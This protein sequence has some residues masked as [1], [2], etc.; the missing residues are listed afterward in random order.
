MA[1]TNTLTGRENLLNIAQMTHN[2]EIID[3][4]EVLNETNDMIADAHVERAND[5]TSHVVSRRTLMPVPTWTKVGEGWVPTAGLVNQV[6]EGIATMRSR[7]QAPQQ[8][9]DL[10]PNPAKARQQQERAHIEAMGHEFS[11]TVIAGSMNASPE[12]FNGLEN[13]YG[14]LS[15]AAQIGTGAADVQYVLN[16]GNTTGSDSTSIW[17]LQWGPGKVYLVYPRNSAGGGIKKEDKGLVLTN[18]DNTA[19]AAGI[20][21]QI[22]AFITEFS[23][24]VGLVVEDTRAVKRLANIDSVAG[25]T[26]TLNEDFIIQI[27]NN[28]Q[29]PGTVFMY[30]NETIFT[31]LQILA[32]DKQN[33]F[34]TQE[35]PFGKPQLMFQDMP[36]RRMDKQSITNTESILTT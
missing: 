20:T 3:V 8:V 36:V 5:I 21:A 15:T 7:Y 2:Q 14:T 6:R 30:C 33:V 31:Q 22:W 16:N 28:F 12:E 34:W 10:Q 17:F 13:R 9:L 25:E 29:T 32:K 18:A 24:E 35:A 19:A 1:T 26:F 23:W 27:R 11:R 4:A